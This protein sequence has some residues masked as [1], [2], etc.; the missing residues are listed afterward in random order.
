MGNNQ[1]AIGDDH[2]LIGDVGRLEL[3]FSYIGD[4]RLLL[5]DIQHILY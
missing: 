3:P 2:L 5:R 1:L 4:Y